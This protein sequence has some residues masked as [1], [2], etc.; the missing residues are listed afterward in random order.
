[1]LPEASIHYLRRVELAPD[2]Q[3]H[4][5]V[6]R[7]KRLWPNDPYLQREWVRAV[8]VVLS[9]KRGWLLSWPQPRIH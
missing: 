7:A 1:M 9:T 3:P 5:L 2:P 4:P 8:G 6:A